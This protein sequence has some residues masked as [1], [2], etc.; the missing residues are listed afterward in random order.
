L[1][2][3]RAWPDGAL[4]RFVCVMARQNVVIVGTAYLCD[5]EGIGFVSA[6]ATHS[7]AAAG[8]AP[9]P[10]P[11]PIAMERGHLSVAA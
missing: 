2:V 8:E 11:L 6:E 3:A 10:V 1:G 4:A 5:S 7:P 9:P